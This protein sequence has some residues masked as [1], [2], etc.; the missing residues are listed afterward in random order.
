MSPS[1][2]SAPRRRAAFTIVEVVVAM[3]IL[4]LGMTSILGLLSFGAALART[5]ALRNSAASAID[6]VVGD[7]QESFFPLVDAPG[8]RR[9]VA[10]VPTPIEGREVPGHDGIL[11]SARPTPVPDPDDPQGPARAWRVDIEISWTT[12]GS[13][14][15]RTFQTLL[16]REVPFG[17]RLRREFLDRDRS[18]PPAAAGAPT[19]PKKEP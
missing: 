8:G 18:P 3:G 12:Q 2:R 19:A 1:P 17:E 11:Y 16:L 7:L 10:G 9:K 4:L 15:S 14:R 13:R 5:A 6:A